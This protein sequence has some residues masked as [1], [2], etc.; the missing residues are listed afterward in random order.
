M[1][2]NEPTQKRVRSQFPE[3]VGW[4]G[5]YARTVEHYKMRVR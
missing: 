4:E 2:Q 3:P 5:F 1:A